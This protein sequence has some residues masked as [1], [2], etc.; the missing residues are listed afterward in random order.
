VLTCLFF[1]VDSW[2]RPSFALSLPHPSRACDRGYWVTGVPAPPVTSHPSRAPA[3]I[4][5][6]YRTHANPLP[7][8]PVIK[9]RR[10]A[11]P[12]RQ[13][14]KTLKNEPPPKKTMWSICL[15]NRAPKWELSL[16]STENTALSERQ[17]WTILRLFSPHCLFAPSSSPH[18]S[19]AP[20]TR[21]RCDFVCDRIYFWFVLPLRRSSSVP[22]GP[23]AP[24]PSAF[25][26]RPAPKPRRL[27]PS[28]RLSPADVFS[29]PRPS[30]RSADR[31]CS[32]AGRRE[33]C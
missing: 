5:P 17:L 25:R 18:T 4:Q 32:V 2:S 11:R 13:S 9:S 33:S 8:A 1:C 14:E 21:I 31:A 19:A 6:V 23:A 30:S 20:A 22:R 15:Q 10:P 7:P 26:K 12:R 27:Q 29:V 28:A 3:P 16:T 24:I